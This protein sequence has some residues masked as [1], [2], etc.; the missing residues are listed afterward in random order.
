[1][2]A[3]IYHIGGNARDLIITLSVVG[4]FIWLVF[5]VLPLPQIVRTILAVI[6]AVLLL[7]SLVGCSTYDVGIGGTYQDASGHSYGANVQLNQPRG[8]RK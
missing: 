1:M 3:L 8:Y 6:V 5:F 4:V 7:L 2:I